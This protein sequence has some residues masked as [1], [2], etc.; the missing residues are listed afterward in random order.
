MNMNSFIYQRGT[1]VHSVQSVVYTILALSIFWVG[2][3][4]LHLLI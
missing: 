2:V 3:I 1:L 4:Q